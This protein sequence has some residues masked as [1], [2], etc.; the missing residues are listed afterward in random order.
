MDENY[1]EIKFSRNTNSSC[2]NYFVYLLNGKLAANSSIVYDAGNRLPKPLGPF[3]FNSLKCNRLNQKTI[4]SVVRTK[5]ADTISYKR[6]NN[7]WDVQISAEIQIQNTNNKVLSPQLDNPTSTI[8]S[9][10]FKLEL[11]DSYLELIPYKSI[12]TSTSLP[13]S[14]RT[15]SNKRVYLT[16][17][18]VDSLNSSADFSVKNSLD[19]L[20]FHESKHL[21]KF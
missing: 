16:G 4:H 14:E 8:A 6:S 5:L 15:T 10:T 9:A 19:S 21:F 12:I 7:D 17:T 20:K 1:V 18:L 11:N 3:C 2:G 13:A